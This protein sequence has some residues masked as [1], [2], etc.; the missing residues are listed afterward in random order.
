MDYSLDG[1]ELAGYLKPIERVGFKYRKLIQGLLG[2][3]VNMNN[4]LQNLKYIGI[5]ELNTIKTHQFTSSEESFYI[6]LL[7]PKTF[8]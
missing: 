4:N 8:E 2:Y 7:P 5:R 6:I 3:L 1:L